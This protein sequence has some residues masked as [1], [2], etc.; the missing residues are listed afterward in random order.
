MKHP[1]VGVARAAI[2]VL[3]ASCGSDNG[4]SLPAPPPGYPTAYATAACAPF[5]GPATQLYLAAEPAEALPPPAPF[6]EVA[7]WQGVM[8][9]SGRRIEWAGASSSG[10]ARRCDPAGACVEATNVAVQFRPVGADTT[11][12]GVVALNFADGSTATGGFNA[13]WRHSQLMCG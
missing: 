10:M 3:L 9:L 12:T 7:I 5:D 2:L 8:S 4:L 11:V 1:S 6:I 13:A